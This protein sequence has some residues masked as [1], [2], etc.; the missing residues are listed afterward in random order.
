MS[1]KVNLSE[2]IAEHFGANASYVEGLLSRYESDPNLVDESWRTFFGELLN[3]AST[4]DGG[5]GQAPAAATTTTTNFSA[6][7]ASEKTNGAPTPTVPATEKKQASLALGADVDVRPITGAGKKIVEN[8]ELSLSVPTATSTRRIPVKLLE[9]NRRIINENLQKSG[10]KVSF[11]H[12]IAWAIVKAVKSYPQMNFGYGF[13]D[14]A[15]SRLAHESLNLGIAIDI[16]KKDGSRNLLV[17]NIKGSDKLNFAGFL[18]EYNDTVKRARDGKLG[19]EDFQGTTISL[20]NPGTIGTVASNPRLMSGQGVIIATGAIEYPAEYQAMTSSTL[21]Q[22]GISKVLTITSTYDHRVIQGAESGLFLAKIHE[23]LTGKENFYDE[24]FKD[25]EISY[26]PLRW[27]ED[28]NPSLFGGDNFR[29]QTEKQAKVLELI[30]AYRIRGHLLADVDPLNMTSHYSPELDLEN[31]KLTIWDLDRE[32]ITGGLHG[33][34]TATLR[35][36]L[37]ILRRAYCGKVGIEYRHIQSKDEKQWIR[38]QVRKEFVDTVALSPDVR[39]QLLQ[40][41]IE[42]EQFEQFL[43]KKYLGQKRFSLEGTETVIPMLD[44]LVELSSEKGV[45]EIFVGMAHRGRLNVLSNIIGNAETGDLAERIFTVFE[46]TSHP[47]FPADEGDVKYHQGAIGERKTRIGKDVRIQLSS[48]PSHLEFVDAVVEGMARARQDQL[49]TDDENSRQ[50]MID[51]VLPVLM[52][53][54]AAFAGQGIVMETLQLANLKGYRTG[55][56]IHIVINNQIGFTTSPESSRSS[57]YSTDAAQITQLP[58]FHI[59]GDDPEAAYRTVRIALDYRQE[60]NKDVALDLIGFRRLGH[61]EGD[62]PTYTQPL[63]YAKVKAHPG[64]RH[65][66]AQ[67][68]IREGVISEND[69]NEMTSRVVSKYEEILRRAKQIAA[70]KQEKTTLKPAAAEEDGSRLFETGVSREILQTVSNKISLVPEGFNVNPKMVGQLARR[71]KMGAGSVPM[72]WGFAEA[73]AF[74]SLVLEGNFVRLSGQD[75]GRGTF[76][77]RHA[78]MYDTQT[79]AKWSPLGELRSDKNPRARFHVFDSSLSEQGVLGFEYGY[80]TVAQDAFVAWEAQ[81]GDFAN[82]AQVII[83]QYIAAS[84]D[85]WGQKC[86]LTMLLPHGY[87]G[88]GP[89]HSSARLERFLQLCAENNLQVC[90]PTTPAQYFHLLR[91][92]VHQE[93]VRALIV[94]T[95]K[96]LL[97]LPAAVSTIEELETGGFQ[98]VIDDAKV[99]D[100]AKVKRIVLC[101]GKVFYD[102]DT[103]RADADDDRVAIVRLEQFYPFPAE[104]LKEVFAAYPNATQLFWTQEEPQNMGGWLFVEQRLEQIKGNLSLRYVGRT[105]SASPA[106]GSYAIHNLEQEKLVNESL[107]EDSTEISAASTSEVSR[108]IAP[109]SS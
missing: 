67:Q 4:S 94:M 71:A 106:T 53:G 63:M 72:D 105:A 62:E 81:F 18:K 52:H 51:K 30:N 57:I 42:A 28:Y 14:N 39:K 58:I 66:Y 92:Q 32:F 77:Q 95:P 104:K 16:E 85:K 48:N 10:Q 37:S 31:Y 55:G 50:L 87:E 35:E 9:E 15:P 8:M 7:P 97:R 100:K 108:Q 75:S 56:T 40:K 29:E 47:S 65:L 43:H 6:S 24:I 74:G 54:D 99:K 70:D 98:P 64:V 17:P 2:Y 25:L 109:A 44:Q 88:Q 34:E 3:G 22:L 59:N 45:E 79:G 27:A 101:S 96:S 78:L 86:R 38:E 83:D 11:T 36:I 49:R 102:L 23:Y 13:I 93:I 91:R 5:N 103:A 21:S 19:I 82:G 33:T 26:P 12:I 107:I 90:Y 80:S 84:E 46:G 68:L 20:T 60:F 69:L 89:E 1:D 41:L 73:L 76:S 61:N